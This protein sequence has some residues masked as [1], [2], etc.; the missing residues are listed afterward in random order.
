[1]SDFFAR[2]RIYLQRQIFIKKCFILISFSLMLLL[3]G[4]GLSKEPDSSDFSAHAP[5]EEDRLI[6]YTS[7]LEEIYAPIIKEF[8]ERT[9]I[10]VQI[11]TGGSI[12]LLERIA[13]ESENPR[14]DLIFGGGVESLYSYRKWFSP[15]ISSLEKDI[16]PK[17]RQADGIWTPF[18]TPT[19]VLIY[20]TKLIRT[21]PPT[22]WES[23]LDPAWKGRIAF[24]DPESSASSYTA[25][26][27]MLQILPGDKNELIQSFYNNLDGRTLDKAAQVVDEVA[28]GSCYIGITLEENALRDIKNGHDIGMVYPSEGTC[29]VPDGLAIIS[30]S[31]H[32][33]NARRFIDFALEND[34]QTYISE[35]CNLRPVRSDVPQ[36]EGVAQKF[37]QFSYDSLWAGSHQE[38]ILMQWHRLKEETETEPDRP[39]TGEVT[40]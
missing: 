9:G 18:S 36:P 33:E 19:V 38:E 30:G 28:N 40:P 25:L 21:N 16:S 12:E 10:W 11:E 37:P 4:C 34:V 17:Y 22:G 13:A 8:E 7:F 32:E 14:C 29:S 20:N 2:N 15:Y 6:I 23:L 31:P 35:L 5:A 26:S 3:S 39:S 1:M 24:A 27:I